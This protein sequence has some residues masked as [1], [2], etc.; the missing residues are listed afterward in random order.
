M[1]ERVGPVSMCEKEGPKEKS[2]VKISE[3]Q[4]KNGAGG[5]GIQGTGKGK[6]PDWRWDTLPLS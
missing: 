2:K 6:A 3:K 4:P 5:N 1:W